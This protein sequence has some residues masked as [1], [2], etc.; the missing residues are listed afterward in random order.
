MHPLSADETRKLLEAARRD[1]LEALYVL[2]I[3]TG[4]RQGELLALRWQDVDLETATISVRRTLTKNGG[5]LLLGEPKT[6]K[7]RRTIQLTEAA[8]RVL[9]EHLTH[10]M[11]HIQRL[12]DLY[13]DEGLIF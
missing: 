3:H 8:V 4:M 5:R 7:S 1:K 11:E 2:A 6:K 9:R 10:Q 13:R 12:G